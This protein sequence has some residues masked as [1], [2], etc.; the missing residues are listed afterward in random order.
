MLE[1]GQERRVSSPSDCSA[2]YQA[3]GAVGGGGEL[4]GEGRL[5]RAGRGDD[6]AEAV[7]AEVRGRS[8]VSRCLGRALILRTRIF[9]AGTAAAAAPAFGGEVSLLALATLIL[10]APGLCPDGDTAPGGCQANLVAI[11]L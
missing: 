3:T 10:L 4:G 11:H 5:A 9:A 2:A 1:A 7:L 8:A 6:E